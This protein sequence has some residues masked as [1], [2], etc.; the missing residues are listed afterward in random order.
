MRSLGAAESTAEGQLGR[1]S[2][3]GPAALADGQRPLYCESVPG[4]CCDESSE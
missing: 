2:V 3:R 1:L 4:W